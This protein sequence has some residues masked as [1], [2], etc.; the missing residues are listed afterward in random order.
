MRITELHIP[1]TVDAR[2][3]E[4]VEVRNAVERAVLGT[5]ALAV[6]AAELLP[7]YQMQDHAPKRIVVAEVDGRLVARGVVDGRLGGGGGGPVW[8]AVEVLPEFR[9]RGIG[10]ALA[11]YLEALAAGRVLQATALHA[12]LPG[13]ERVPSPSGFGDVPAAD[14][15]VRFLRRRGYRLEQVKRISFLDVPLPPGEL[16]ARYA[17]AAARAG[18]DYRVVSWVGRTPPAWLGEIAALRTAMATAAPLAGLD[19]DDEPW[20]EGRVVAADNRLLVAG[21]AALTVAAEHRPTG[22]LA[23]FSELWPPLD[24]SRAV[25]QHDTLVLPEHRGR[26]LGMVLK[27]ANLRLLAATAPHYRLVQTFNAEEN[28]PM[29]DVNEAIGFRPVGAEGGWRRDR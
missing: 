14:P 5:D 10:T 23:G 19:P 28:R 9:G 7:F 21:R 26:R 29:L 6:T 17:E 25:H 11:D 3:A 18:D 4:M 15:G 13:G 2:F 8:L 12:V 24:P 16:D 27:L 22:R 20:D 1:R